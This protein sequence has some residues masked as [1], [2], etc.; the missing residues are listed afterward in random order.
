MPK[1]NNID[2]LFQDKLKGLQ[3]SPSPKVWGAIE[4]KIAPKKRRIIPLWWFSGIAALFV[5]GF[6]L[7]P[8]TEKTTDFKPNDVVENSF[9]VT[10]KDEIIENIEQVFNNNLEKENSKIVESNNDKVEEAKTQK[11]KTKDIKQKKILEKKVFGKKIAVKEKGK[12]NKLT[13]KKILENENEINHQQRETINISSTRTKKQNKGLLKKTPS[14]KSVENKENGYLITKK[15]TDKENAEKKRKIWSISTNFAFINSGSFSNSSPISKNVVNTTQGQNS[16]AYGVQVDFEINK[17]WSIRSGLQLQ[18]LNYLDNDVLVSASTSSLASVSF[19]DIEAVS[20]ESVPENNASESFDSLNLR[21]NNITIGSL[22]QQFGYIEIP[23]E[24]K[25]T[26]NENNTLK[27]QLVGGFSSL[28]LTSN[29]VLLN[30]D[31]SNRTG[32]ASNLNN[33]N[34]SSNLGIDFNYQFSKQWFFSVNPMLKTFLNTFSDRANGFSPFN[35]GI[36]SG[37]RYKF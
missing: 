26:I 5:L 3:S 23:V 17:K 27:T 19:N 20:I 2:K 4:N 7:F 6:F 13:N 35:L 14:K 12:S 37:V 16:L 18:Q 25:Y 22:Q 24:L 30:N 9:T 8:F 36:Y 28:F 32:E 11:N 33:I 31:F 10:E 1:E 29:R 21:T 34:F 15:G